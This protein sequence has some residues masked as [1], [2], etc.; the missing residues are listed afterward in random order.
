[1]YNV[2]LIPGDGIGPEIAA[3]T[4]KII[5]AT[6]VKINWEEVNAGIDVYEKTGELVPNNVFESIEKNKIALKGPITTPIGKGFRS[7]N[8]Q[9]RKKYDLYSN[10]REVKSFEG[11]KSRYE[12]IDMVIFRENTEGLYIGKEN[13][14]D[15]ET[16]EAIKVITKKGST[17]IVKAAFEYAKKNNKKVVTVAHKANILKFADGLFLNC[18]REVAKDYPEIELK[19]VI[20]DNMCMQMVINP[21]QFEVIVTMNLYGDILSDLAAGLIGGLGMAPGANIGEDI[22]IFEAVHGSAP[23]IA[24]KNLANPTALLLS[25][26]SM[27]RYL[28]ENKRADIILTALKETFK[29]GKVLTKDLGG[30]ATTTEFGDYL[31]D[32]ISALL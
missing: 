1:M 14:I 31:V 22:A 10:V 12:N 25:G 6:K 11:I 7:I 9:L 4:K 23:D 19:E 8:V 28:G 24:G 3:I 32:K 26:I 21:N 13:K 2:T 18:A 15:E 16:V 29:E 5:D 17:R 27:L 20:I 30:N